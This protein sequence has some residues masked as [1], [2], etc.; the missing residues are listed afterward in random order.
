[1]IRNLTQEYR[2]Y[3]ILFQKINNKLQMWFSI[4]TDDILVLVL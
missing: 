2:I 1:M 3:F 4:L